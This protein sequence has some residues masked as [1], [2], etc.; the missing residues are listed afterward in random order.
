MSICSQYGVLNSEHI[1]YQSKPLEFKKSEKYINNGAIAVKHH[2]DLLLKIKK[3]EKESNLFFKHYHQEG[4]ESVIISSGCNFL[5]VNEVLQMLDISNVSTIKLG[6]TYPLPVQLLASALKKY[7]TVY[8]AEELDGYL[9]FQLLSIMK[10]NKIDVELKSLNNDF[11]SAGDLSMDKLIK[12]LS[13]EFSVKYN[14]SPGIPS[15][16]IPER[17]GT[18]CPGCP[19]RGVLYIIQQ[20]CKVNDVYGGDIGCSSLPPYYSDWLTCMGSGM[21]I[22]HGVATATNGNGKVYTSIGDSTFYHS[23][24]PIIANALNQKTNL[25]LFILNNK[26]TA[27][28]GHQ[29]LPHTAKQEDIIKNIVT[30]LGVSH[31]WAVDAYDI[32]AFRKHLFDVQNLSGLKVFVVNGECSQKRLQAVDQQDFSKKI[33]CKIIEDAC[34]QCDRCYRILGCPAITTKNHSYS[35]DESICNK[36]GVCAQICPNSSISSI[37]WSKK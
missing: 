25:T 31:V 30:S 35:I 26:W 13:R 15:I 36:C 24:I 14:L 5:A 6:M 1:H 4:S 2:E 21:G 12:N 20:I 33:S 9:Y 19:H 22:A 11:I 29:A 8:I 16:K 28:T 27:M 18:F 7:Q 32:K 23:G 10:K 34:H 17:P 37:E 3:V